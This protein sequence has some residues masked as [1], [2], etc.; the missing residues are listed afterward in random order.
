MGQGTRKLYELPNGVELIVDAGQ[1]TYHGQ[2]PTH[3]PSV[4][5][6]FRKGSVS[7]ADASEAARKVWQS[8]ATVTQSFIEVSTTQAVRTHTQAMSL[9][10][11]FVDA[12]TPL[13]R[14]RAQATRNAASAARDNQY[15]NGGQRKG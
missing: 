15:V 8:T 11:S 9:C 7:Q 3:R 10:D 13:L 14:A 4:K 12:L 6:N 2:W 1:F 5:L